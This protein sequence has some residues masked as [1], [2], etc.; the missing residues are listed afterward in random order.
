ME[1][2]FVRHTA[3]AIEK[4]ICYGQTDLDVASTFETELE[5]VLTQLPT[6]I[7]AVFSSPLQR[8]LKL[9]SKIKNTPIRDKRI[10]EL[11]FGDW[12]MQKWDDI[13]LKE[14]QRWYDDFVYEA[15]LNGESYNELSQRAI[16][17]YNDVLLLEHKVVV[18][19][20]HSGVIRS[21]LAYVNN[22]KLKESFDEFKIPYGAVFK[23]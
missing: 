11:N 16:E 10:V 8:C 17:F 21:L 12:E 13:P 5:G 2:Y 7:D 23:I 18:I 20:T 1:I 14:I 9:A 6:H 22:I 15:C 3:P 4:G 19:V